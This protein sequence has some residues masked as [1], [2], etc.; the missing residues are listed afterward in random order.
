MIGW[1]KSSS[2]AF[3]VRDEKKEQSKKG[4]WI[5]L[6]LILEFGTFYFVSREFFIKWS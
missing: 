4:F 6:M 1:N 2:I 5:D 3:R